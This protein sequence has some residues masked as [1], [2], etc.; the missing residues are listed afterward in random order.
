[1]GW[2]SDKQDERTGKA[3]QKADK[4]REEARQKKSWW[5]KT[6]EDERKERDRK[7]SW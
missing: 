2:F 4:E 1:M 7:S 6:K 3:I 5:D